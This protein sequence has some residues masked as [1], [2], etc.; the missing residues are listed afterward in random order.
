ML[1]HLLRTVCLS[2]V[3]AL[4]L[5]T[6]GTST[7]CAQAGAAG[8]L[9]K[10]LQSGRLPKERQPQVVE[11]VVTR[12]GPDDLAFIVGEV[13]KDDAFS[14]PLRRQSLTWLADAARVRK[15]VPSGDLSAIK[16]LLTGDVTKRDPAI[17]NG[18]IEL[19]GL[20]KVAAVRPQ[21]QELAQ[22]D[23][24]PAALRRAAIGGL[25]SLGDAESKQTIRDLAS[26]GKS[27]QLR[28]LAA[29]ELAAIDLE[30]AAA[31]A[32][33]IIPELTSKIDPAPLLDAIL[34]RKEGAEKLAAQLKD[35]KIPEEAAKISL[36]HMYSVGRSDAAL[37]DVLSQAANIALDAP[38][39]TQ[40]EAAKI[41]A[42]VMAKGNAER[43]EQIF[44]R[45][46]LSCIKCHSIAQAG[47]QVGPELTALGSISP[48]DYVVNSIL[49]PNL[50]IKEQYV[51]R[52]LLT[53][54]GGVVT[55]IVIDR[56]DT[57][58]RVRDAAGK[59]LTIPAADIEDEA[60]GKSLMPQ[61]LTKFLTHD[62]FLDLARFVS[63][64]GKPGPYAVRKVPT[65]QRWR[66]LSSPEKLV[67][68]EV[69]NVELLREH[70]L[71]TP[72]SA[73]TTS[74]GMA[75]GDF[76]LAELS[77]GSEG[78]ALYLQGQ[79]DVIDTG[80]IE[81]E[82]TAPTGTVWWLDAEPFEGTTLAKREIATGTHRVTIR[83]PK[84]AGKLR[85]EIRKPTDST[86]NYTVLGGQ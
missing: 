36:R 29:A 41:A 37:S 49:N 60:E 38:P 39:P 18:A 73:W 35:K 77:S 69:P 80:E 71:D 30:A 19:A 76:P 42:E 4:G 11:M 22:S 83:V 27:V 21:L 66:V 17:I 33:T 62:E 78:A 61:G 86:A 8:P 48:A 75:G 47:G 7:A 53:A 5:F 46:D 52:V 74:Y 12:G 68:D 16:Q 24:T 84:A 67:L 59:I 34:G 2:L 10:L 6:F 82:L 50:A 23:K 14:A 13:I 54:D 20:W 55:G 15:V 65:I 85:M 40:E 51:T 63:E 25:V 64:L 58:V 26:S 45:K 32:G 81:L 28:L 44:R 1:T 72:D 43:G 57:R 3:L 9:L 79:F 31:A 70:V 56:D